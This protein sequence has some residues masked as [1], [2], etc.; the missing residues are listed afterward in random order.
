MTAFQILVVPVLL[1]LAGQALVGCIRGRSRFM[2][3]AR[4]MIWMVGA[5]LV[6]RPDALT[7]VAHWLG[8]GRGTDLLLYAVSVA[9]TYGF[10][11]LKSRQW[12]MEAALTR[13]ARQ[14]ALD[15]AE[16]Q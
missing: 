12:G 14:H 8:I 3:M 15:H 1:L 7:V 2:N 16:E 10:L 9:A 4:G 11:H 5:A 6:Y 13:L